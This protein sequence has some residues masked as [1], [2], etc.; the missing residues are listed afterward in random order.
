MAAPE[1]HSELTFVAPRPRSEGEV[2]EMI[3]GVIDLAYRGSDGWV[4]ADFKTDVGDD[5][6]F[7]RRSLAYRM[8]VELY[9]DCWTS[10]TGEPVTERV[11]LYTAQDREERW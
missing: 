2:P 11:L 10:M 4:I 5:P 3:E 9:A 7:P 6:D 8:Q 1:R